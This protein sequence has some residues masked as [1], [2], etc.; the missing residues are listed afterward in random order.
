MKVAVAA[1]GGEVFRLVGERGGR[2]EGRDLGRDPVSK[3]WFPSMLDFLS[4]QSV[5]PSIV[6]S[7]AS[8]LPWRLK[9]A[10]QDCANHA[11]HAKS[12]EGC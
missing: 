11:N 8:S 1:D 12:F 6:S 10:S 5:T 9:D 4:N 3:C 2:Q 7:I